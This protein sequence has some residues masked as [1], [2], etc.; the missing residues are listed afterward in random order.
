MV[1][2]LEIIGIL[3]RLDQSHLHPKLEDPILICP[4]REPTRASAVGGEHIIAIPNIYV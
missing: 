3:K 1:L 4:G 2:Y